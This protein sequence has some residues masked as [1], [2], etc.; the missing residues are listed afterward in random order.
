[1]R[2]LG[3]SRSGCLN[4]EATDQQ[5]LDRFVSGPGAEAE[6]AF[7]ALLYRHGSMVLG[8]CRQF[9][10]GAHDAD[11]AFQATFL[12]LVRRAPAIRLTGSRSLGNWLYGVAHRVA[13]R[14]RASAAL[15]RTHESR[16]AEMQKR[17]RWNPVAWSDLAPLLLE[18]VNRLPANE[19]A[20]V[21]L[22]YFEGLTHDEAAQQLGW[23][24]GSVKGRLARARN[25][26]R[27]RLERR[28]GSLSAGLLAVMLA[29]QGMA[30]APVTKELATQ[31][32]QAAFGAAS[33]S[34]TVTALAES[35]AGAILG[36]KVT[37]ATI[38]L[39]SAA[40]AL[41]VVSLWPTVPEHLLSPQAHASEV[42]ADVPWTPR[43]EAGESKMRIYASLANQ[44]EI[45]PSRSGSRLPSL[46]P[47]R[48]GPPGR[49]S[50]AEAGR[51][52]DGHV[53]LALW[54]EARGLTA[55]RLKHLAMA[56]LGD[57]RNATA[58]GLLGLVSYRGHW[59][60]PEAVAD[61]MRSDAL[62]AAKL[63]EYNARRA[64]S[65]RSAEGH[66]QLAL[67]CAE[68]GLKAE[69]EAHFLA[70]VRL[71]PGREAAWRRLGR[72][73]YNGRW[74]TAEQIAS[75]KTKRQTQRKADQFWIPLLVN[76]REGLHQKERRAQA[77]HC[78]AA[79]TDEH[80]I[81]SIWRVFAQ[82]SDD[83]LLWA[84][85]LFGQID[86]PAATRALAVI[87]A[88]TTFPEARR[89]AVETLAG[90]DPRE[91]VGYLL[92]LLRDP[93]PPSDIILYRFAV[94]PTGGTAIGSPGILWFE[95]REFSLL[96]IYTIDE[97]FQIRP[98]AYPAMFSID[99]SNRVLRQQERQAFDLASLIA[100][101]RPESNRL[102]LIHTTIRQAN[103]LILQTLSAIT[104]QNFGEDNEAWRK[105]WASE[106]GYAY[107][108]P[109][110]SHEP[111][112]SFFEPKPTFLSSVHYSCF[113]ASTPVQTQSGPRPIETLDVG[114]QVL[115]QEPASGALSFQP[116]VAVAHNRPADTL[117][118]KLGSEEIIVTG[119]HHFW[120]AGRG[121]VMARDLKPGD[122][123]RTYLGTIRVQS[124]ERDRFQ[125]VFNLEVANNPSFFVGR[126]GTLVHDNTVV[127]PPPRLFDAGADPAAVGN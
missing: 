105:W 39:L 63:A 29:P 15:R 14:A 120:K 85:Q 21:V 106:Q 71:D 10:H 90:R 44:S 17:S 100:T 109:P 12:V 108:P 23:P 38:L 2:R 73:K 122:M 55:E 13:A 117:R 98:F 101:T 8:I 67:W 43:S 26:L 66:W 104:K 102:M 93:W 79:L 116:I 96:R 52:P 112:F 123:V 58:R 80:A 4:A 51:D 121:W 40:M 45:D 119:I 99:Y 126:S 94:M 103:L 83:D 16:S 59:L 49:A 1:M 97:S 95:G 70:V 89:R 115:S 72:K 7:E 57:P 82:G 65:A 37:T 127:E 114:D 84:V 86:T 36:A 125:H 50:R 77:E 30:D 25:R 19:R 34:T 78:L 74:M 46:N 41:S 60:K 47:A 88:F 22:C 107:D 111:D 76:W 35:V 32:L 92:E 20:V 11:D 42:P 118:V 124:V 91:S 110:R 9:L 54:C 27:V 64:K 33:V 48:Q 31:T 3:P 56:V 87:A 62:L 81:P 18:E 6:V 24:I 69:S 113:A 75:E 61:R 5:L 68:N 53:R 28:G